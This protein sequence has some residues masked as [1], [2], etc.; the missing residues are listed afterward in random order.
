[1]KTR[2]TK[3]II[4]TEAAISTHPTQPLPQPKLFA[5]STPEQT[6]SIYTYIYIYLHISIYINIHIY[7]YSYYVYRAG[8]NR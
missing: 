1:M 5:S 8:I 4:V 3:T 6:H 7:E 2:Q